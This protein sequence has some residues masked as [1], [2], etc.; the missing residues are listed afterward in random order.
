MGSGGGGK[1][2]SDAAGDVAGDVAADAAD[3]CDAG[4]DILLMNMVTFKATE[5]LA[6]KLTASNTISGSTAYDSTM[7]PPHKNMVSATANTGNAIGHR[8]LSASAMDA[9]KSAGLND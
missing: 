6:T 3:D 9:N 4:A 2:S 7:V 1:S 5:R 8:A